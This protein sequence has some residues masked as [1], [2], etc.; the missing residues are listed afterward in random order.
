MDAPL[1]QRLTVMADDVRRLA[2]Q[3]AQVV[4]RMVDR[5]RA[6]GAGAEAPGIGEV[7]P[8]FVLPDE[9]GRL[10]SLEELHKAGAVVVAFLRGHWCPYCRI[11]ADALAG[12][13]PEIRLRGGRLA[14]L[15]PE[16]QEFNA[17][18]KADAAADCPILT[19]LDNGYALALGLA[20]QL[21]DEKRSAML[22]AGWDIAGFHA[23]DHWILPIPA[24]FV[25][26]RSGTVRGRFVDPDYRKRMDIEDLL[27]ALDTARRATDRRR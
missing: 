10:V 5:L 8:P 26:D 21:D 1:E 7:M 2:P 20:I 17:A 27:R 6:A 23:N 4:D 11:T 13:E 18:L 25:V 15:T 12:V 14:I 24:I 19:D 16:V 3:F 9:T 22:H